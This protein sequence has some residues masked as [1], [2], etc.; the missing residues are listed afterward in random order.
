MRSE[1]GAELGRFRNGVSLRFLVGIVP[2]IL[3]LSGLPTVVAEP[4]PVYYSFNASNE[5]FAKEV[6]QP[7]SELTWD[8]ANGRVSVMSNR[9]DTA[10]E[11]FT[12]AIAA[13]GT[14]TDFTLR[15]RWATTAQGNWQGAF[16]IFL[17]ASGNTQVGAANSVYIIYS[18]RDN[19]DST[20]S[21]GN[22][23]P[24]YY[25]RYVDASGTIRISTIYKAQ[26]LEVNKEYRFFIGYAAT[27]RVLTMQI[28]DA[29][30]V[31]LATGSYVIGSNPNDGF[32]FGKVGIA[33]D[34]MSSTTEPVT[35]AWT[36]DIRL[37][38]VVS[39]YDVFVNRNS[40]AGT[41]AAFTWATSPSG[42]CDLFE[43]GTT[44]SYGSSISP[45]CGTHSASL[46]GLTVHTTYYYRITS[47]ASGYTSGTYRSSFYPTDISTSHVY[48]N[49]P[50]VQYTMV[51]GD[52]GWL[53]K[54]LTY[55]PRV[56]MAGDVEHDSASQN[57]ADWTPHYV[58][59]HIDAQGDDWCNI[60]GGYVVP[61]EFAVYLYAKD[62]TT[63]FSNT[64]IWLEGLDV[65]PRVNTDLQTGTVSY[66]ISAGGSYDGV[67][68][69][70]SANFGAAVYSY[71]K[72]W[73]YSLGN[74]GWAYVG[75]SDVQWYWDRQSSL[76]V[77]FLL[78]IGDVKAQP[79]YLD[80]LSFRVVFWIEVAQT[81]CGTCPPSDD[82]P[83]Y[84]GY[85]IETGDGAGSADQFTELQ[86]G[87]QELVGFG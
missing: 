43:W 69:G 81:S 65:R 72:W 38:G 26:N 84:T 36:D 78:K 82:F 32:T 31:V 16:P 1:G 48:E 24:Y 5:G 59:A 34:G 67:S 50:G 60:L 11:L 21:I 13:L 37:F 83:E 63:P 64:D 58:Y 66:S 71:S 39:V 47:S 23:N 76:D 49:Y 57:T 41:T 30:D 25:L 19:H 51:G 42:A 27:P 74:D 62:L 12:H 86:G 75:G 29:A 7:N 44:P 10:D 2:F 40:L 22:C 28:R 4:P 6:D 17:M 68:Y 20:C 46:T 70:A 9:L 87:T 54:K 56:V 61:S 8:S 85:T 45:P 18:S 79:H 3:L 52:C 73:G 15:S 55:N 35:W 80:L 77:T 14:T 53:H 33:S